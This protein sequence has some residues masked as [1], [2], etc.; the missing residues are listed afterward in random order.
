MEKGKKKIKQKNKKKQTKKRSDRKA[1]EIVPTK[2]KK[3]NIIILRSQA[4][5]S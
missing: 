2:T 1:K 3:K 4:P 5:F